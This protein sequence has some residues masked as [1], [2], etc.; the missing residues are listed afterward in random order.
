[1]YRERKKMQGRAC[2]SPA[3]RLANP[4]RCVK[5][6]G[7]ILGRA[8]ASRG[9]GA[10]RE[11]RGRK[12]PRERRSP[13]P[14]PHTPARRRAA[15]GP[16][17]GAEGGAG[18]PRPSPRPRRKRLWFERCRRRTP[19]RGATKGRPPPTAVLLPQFL[20][21]SSRA[22]PARPS[23]SP[24][25]GDAC[26]P[27]SPGPEDTAPVRPVAPKTLG[28]SGAAAG[29]WPSRRGQ[30][31]GLASAS[32]EEPWRRR[33]V[34]LPASPRALPRPVRPARKA[35]SSAGAAARSSGPDHRQTPPP[36]AAPPGRETPG[37]PL[38]PRPCGARS[39]P[40]RAL[41]AAR[42]RAG[43]GPLASLHQVSIP[44]ARA[45]LAAQAAILQFPGF[46]RTPLFPR[47]YP[48]FPRPFPLLDPTGKPK[49]LGPRK[50]EKG[51]GK[52]RKGGGGARRRG[53]AFGG[54]SRRRSADSP[55]RARARRGGSPRDA[56]AS[57]A[58]GFQ[59]SLAKGEAL[60]IQC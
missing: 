37:S 58:G 1:M 28:P 16:P 55:R 10:A 18:C 19:A 52:R 46:L 41:S 24:G 22:P 23:L 34:F 20:H 45:R 53:G 12:R 30:S 59:L 42:E 3:H 38:P 25:A 43:S 44:A 11:T 7:F 15:E 8:G 6:K 57:G 31:R 49:Q 39:P 35:A 21:R 5:A 29:A 2:P 13:P 17:Q 14:L 27:V 51:S 47:P 26:S 32:P 33:L 40:S 48:S 50:R 54:V 4:S 56:R 36:G 9:Q 60:E